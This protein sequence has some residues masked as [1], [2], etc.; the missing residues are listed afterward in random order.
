MD[1]ET[2][3][4][5]TLI[6]SDSNLPTGSFVASSGLES[7]LK[8]GFS[9]LSDSLPAAT[10]TY[11]QNSLHNY[12]HSSLAFVSGAHESMIART[13][14]VLSQL[15]TLDE[16]YEVMT[17]NEVTRRASTTQ[18]V[19]LLTLYSKGFTRPNIPLSESLNS[20]EVEKETTT[21][22]IIDDFKATIRRGDTHGHLPICWGVLTA[23]LG[24]SLSERSYPRCI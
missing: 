13:G 6:L 5:I 19:A 21:L 3:Q 24:L 4:Y 8:H 18:G 10:L 23:A 2:E 7:Y 9:S 20:E 14:D 12:A 17:L 16:G 15:K 1:L 11:I 22:K